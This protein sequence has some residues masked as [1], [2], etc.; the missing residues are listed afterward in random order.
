MLEPDGR[1]LLLDALRPPEGYR[2]DYGVATTFTLHLDTALSVP[3]SFLSRR[4]ADS[5]D[6]IALMEAVRAAADRLDI[7]HQAGMIALPPSRSPI[8][9]F[10]EPVLHAVRRPK[11]GHLFHPKL[12]A[13][14]YVADDDVADVR[15]R[16]L[17]PSRNL[18]ADRSWDLCLQLDGQLG[19][20]PVEGNSPVADLLTALP[21]MCLSTMPPERTAR[22]DALASDLQ[23]TEWELPEHVDDL[24]FDVLGLGH[25]LA[26]DFFV[27]HQ[28]LVI[29]PFCTD[30]GLATVTGGTPATV[31]SRQETLDGLDR[32]ALGEHETFVLDPLTSEMEDNGDGTDP[33]ATGLTGL[34]AKCF[35]LRHGRKAWI[36]VGSANATEAAF[37]G[38]VEILVSLVG[39]AAKLGVTDLFEAESSLRSILTEYSPQ[40]AP[41]EDDVAG[42]LGDL[43]I[44]LASGDFTASVQSTDHGHLIQLQGPAIPTLP[45]G[46]RV[47]VR[48]VTVPEFAAEVPPEQLIDVT[49][50]P[51][52]V[53]QISAF[54][55]IT[56]TT[57]DGVS[58]SAVVLADLVGAPMN[59]LDE[60]IARQV[61]TPE[62][63]LRFLALL[64]GMG[65]P[66]WAV[67]M[68]PVGSAGASAATAF[69]APGL[70]ELLMRALV[71]HP[72][73]LDDLARLV[74]RLGAYA[75]RGSVLP[76]G[77]KEIWAV[78]D[79]VRRDQEA[80]A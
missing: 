53:D 37:A 60:I 18:T 39:S 52:E 77:F 7:F 72:G 38:N 31:V 73:R 6:P 1:A 33:T 10:L 32:N 65:Q 48:P 79:A 34:H 58:A 40:A 69:E 68:K 30:G 13:L 62:K 16:L 47:T 70:L 42:Q 50:G 49:F 80:V 22:L 21:R 63:F 20:G 4:L 15:M 25:S 56:A 26:A 11:A 3:L 8:F 35:I 12:W 45:V 28:H 2:L 29:S 43:L 74:D 17:V 51:M 36:R 61:D 46:A 64:L 44:D 24:S 55:I 78:V 5:G 59:R 76:D 27:G 57:Q 67:G 41:D 9:S 66:A 14:R 23:R 71:E 75:D 54:V 19:P